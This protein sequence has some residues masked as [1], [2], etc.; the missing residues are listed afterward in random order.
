MEEEKE[1]GDRE[2]I[3]MG[4]GDRDGRREEGGRE[5]DGMEEEKE[6]GDREEIGIE[7]EK[8]GAG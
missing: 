6:V 4:E 7:G 1:G 3:G 5:G 8:E 2:E